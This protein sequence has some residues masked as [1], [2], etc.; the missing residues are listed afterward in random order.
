M[1]FESNDQFSF[2]SS[3][4]SPPG[5]FAATELVSPE[6]QLLSMGNVIG[7]TN[8]FFSLFNYGLAEFEGGFGPYMDRITPV[9]DYSSS[10]GFLTYEA[11]GTNVANKIDDLS[12][13]ITAGRLSE[14]NK[15]VLI[16]A[17]KHFSKAYDK[18]SADRV[19]LQLM[20][21]LPEFHTSNTSECTAIIVVYAS[22]SILCCFILRKP[23]LILCIC[24]TIAFDSSQNWISA[25]NCC[26]TT[27]INRAIQSYSVHQFVGRNRQLQYSYSTQ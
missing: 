24:L 14:E 19:L 26:T 23:I 21:A 15:Q 4:Y 27:K 13:L 25:F 12:T 5:S 20:T 6:S 17:Y 8:G 16:E 7:I 9:G 18:E 3:D 1:V 22:N 11:S 10:V 2:F